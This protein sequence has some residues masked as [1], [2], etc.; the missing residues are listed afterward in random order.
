[1]VLAIWPSDFTIRGSS[2]LAELFPADSD[3]KHS[4]K[5]LFL[6]Q[7]NLFIRKP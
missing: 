2:G 4:K 6:T 1:M 7:I 5:F 3:E